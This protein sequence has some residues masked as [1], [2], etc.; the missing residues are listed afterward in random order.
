MTQPTLGLSSTQTGKNLLVSLCGFT[1]SIL[2]AFI[3]WWI[4][5]QFGFAFYTWMFWFVIPIGALLSGFAGASGYYFGSVYFGHRPTPRLLLNIIIASISTFFL[6]YY[7]SYMTLKIEGKS[8]SDYVSF[9]KYIDIT[10][11]SSSMQFRSGGST[12]ELG[13]FGYIVAL[14]Q[15]VGF[16][17]GGFA[18]YAH[19]A[20]KPYCEKCSQY[21]SRKWKRLRYNSNIEEMKVSTAQI[22]D[23]ISKGAI[24]SAIDQHKTFGNSN[25][26]KD[27]CL[28]SVFEVRH[29]DKCGRD[30]VKFS[31]E[32]YSNKDWQEIPNLTAASFIDQVVDM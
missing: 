23:N 8:V 29:C 4:E 11:R 25:P 26:Q 28:R 31:V 21:L 32:K 20:S 15:I 7:L 30:W 14:L 9:I 19:L 13:G 18:V 2:T 27:D 16:A 17:L 5:V 10:I 12:G 22:V 6:V 1:T 24:A 3:L